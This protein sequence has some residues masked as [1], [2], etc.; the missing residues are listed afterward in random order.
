MD[1]ILSGDPLHVENI[2]KENARRVALGWVKFTPATPDSAVHYLPNDTKEV[3][4]ADNKTVVLADE[5]K[6]VTTATNKSAKKSE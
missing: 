1:Y 3:S 2:L 4:V 5:K 6:A